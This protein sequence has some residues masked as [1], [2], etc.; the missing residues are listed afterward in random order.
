MRDGRV[1]MAETNCALPPVLCATPDDTAAHGA[2]IARTM[3]QQL[4]LLHGD[5]GAGKT[6]WT[7]G[8]AHAL[9]YAGPVTS[10]TF[11]V[12]NEYVIGATRLWHLD[13]YRIGCFEEVWDLG[14]FEA[15]ERG[16]RCVIEWPE[17]V[18][19]LSRFDHL[20]ID[21]RVGDDGTRAIT[22]REHREVSP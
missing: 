18:P 7:R 15:L 12:L 19:E 13:L 3:P 11:T 1:G 16:L 4:I 17:R 22:C 8:F 21:I 14:L 6:L 9:G 20:H 5:L 10:P 2:G